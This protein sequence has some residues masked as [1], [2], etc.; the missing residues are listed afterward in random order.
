MT[1]QELCKKIE[2]QESVAERVNAFISSY[3]FSEIEATLQDLIN[4]ETAKSA[5]EKLMATFPEDEDKIKMLSCYLIGVS[6]VYD[7]YQEMGISDE[8]FTETF[9]CFTRFIDECKDKTGKYAFDR[10]FW[11]WR[12]A[13]MLI[14]RI[15]ELE[16]EFINENGKKEVSVHIPSDAKM[17]DD[18]I[19]S[20]LKAA[21]EFFDTYYPEYSDCD[22]V[23]DSW[24]LSPKLKEL[25]SEESNIIRFQNRFEIREENKEAKDIFEWLFKT[26]ED[27]SIETLPEKTSLQRKAKE[28]LLKGDNI[29]I[30]VGVMKK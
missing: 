5:Y 22:Y 26:S 25:L 27:A 13:S 19:D 24:L 18:V 2:L 16:Y 11:T 8:I 4:P 3:D 14:F 12:Q 20:S 17:S 30:A 7:R 23:C 9:K 1:V 21:Q 29:G 6:H 15:G 28:L 10:A